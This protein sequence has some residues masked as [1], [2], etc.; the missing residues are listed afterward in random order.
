M[1]HAAPV[2]P[3]YVQRI[4]PYVPGKPIDD[5]ARELHLDPATI[6]KLA[7][8]ENPRGPSA[9]VLAAIA[10]AAADVTRYPDGFGYHLKDALVRRLGVAADQIVLG[11]GSN[12]ILELVTMAY[13]RQGDAAVFSQHAFAVYPLAT[14][15]RGARASKCRR[16]TSRTTCAAMRARSAPKTR[17]VFV[18]NPNNPTGTWIA[19]ADARGVHRVGAARRAGRARRGVQRVPR[20]G[21]PRRQR[22]LDRDSRTCSCRG[23]SPRPT[24]SRRCASATASCTPTS[25]TC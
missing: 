11:N 19:P 8:N 3:D 9:R 5:V 10:A 13:L 2:A 23:R 20:A 1:T 16:A 22:G 7:S 25:P 24:G 21:G 12:D 14:H 17:I 15:A 18:A 6:V 4:A